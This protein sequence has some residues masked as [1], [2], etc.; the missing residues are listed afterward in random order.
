MK[1]SLDHLPE[2]QQKEIGIIADRLREAFKTV[3]SQGTSPAKQ[4][5]RILKII[6]FGSYAKGC[7]VKD[8]EHGYVSDYDVLVIVNNEKLVEDYRFWSQVEEQIQEEITA[9]FS[10][11][12]HSLTDVNAQLKEGHY[13]FKDIRED[14]ILLYDGNHK[15]LVVPGNL[16][17]EEERDIAERHFAQWF[18]SATTFYKHYAIAV[19]DSDVKE[20]AF[21]LHQTTERFLSCALLVY[22]NYRPKTHNLKRLLALCVQQEPRFEKL[23]PQDTKSH[24]RCFELLKRAYVEAR[25]SEHYSITKEALVWLG[26]QVAVLQSLTETVCRERIAGL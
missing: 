23:F 19:E 12:V 15:P 1:T 11:I 16:S 3:F 9:P 20:A 2:Q 18:K 26:E 7:W 8:P 13:F 17:P 22:T 5:G 6:L 10:P 25:Y 14:G 24:R 21:L 4:S